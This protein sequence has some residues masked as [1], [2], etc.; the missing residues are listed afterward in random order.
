M[1]DLAL[2]ILEDAGLTESDVDDVPS[3]GLATLSPPR[4]I[5]PTTNMNWPSIPGGESFFDRA[6]ANG[7][8]E[9]GA[10]GEL[11]LDGAEGAK[12]ASSAL[13]EWARDEE[14]G[15]GDGAADEDGWDLDVGGEEKGADADGAEGEEGAEGAEEEEELGAGAAPGVS[16]AEVWVRNSP[17]AG[18]HVAAGSFESAMQLLNRQLGIVNFSSLKPLFLSTY[19][20]SHAYLSPLASLPPLNLHLRRNPGE[21]SLTRVLPVTVVTLRQVRQELSEGFRFVSGNKLV[22]AQGVFRAVLRSLLVVAVTSNEEAKEV[23]IPLF[24]PSILTFHT[25]H[26]ISHMNTANSGATP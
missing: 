7:N 13:D 2:E 16:E 3:F 6:L 11:Y 26:L 22:E 15:E 14:E 20:S 17:F 21:S 23:C 5:N 18:D 1:E 4:I 8:L 9:A 19:R 10:G 25:R 24:L 12:A